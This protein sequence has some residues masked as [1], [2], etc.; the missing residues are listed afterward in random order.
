MDSRTTNFATIIGVALRSDQRFSKGQWTAYLASE[1]FHF[2]KSPVIRNDIKSTIKMKSIILFVLAVPK[3]ASTFVIPPT[4]NVAK[5]GFATTPLL[6]SKE[7]TATVGDNKFDLTVDLPP[8]GS[9][10]QAQMKLKP[11]LSVPS[12]IVVVRYKIPFG[13]DVAPKNNL[14]VCTKD[15]PGGEKVGDVLRFTT[16]WKLGLPSP[17]SVMASFSSISG[18]VSWQVSL[19]NVVEAD[20]WDDVVEALVSNVPVSLDIDFCLTLSTLQ[21]RC[22][23]HSLFSQNLCYQLLQDRT[24]EVVLIFERPLEEAPELQ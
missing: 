14:A 6:A 24:D 19:F 21:L 7:G 1:H 12:E 13:L 15:G 4:T 5:P 23:K 22:C 17:D 9:G 8:S 3:M 20:K 10:L 16:Q 18:G 11:I 2:T